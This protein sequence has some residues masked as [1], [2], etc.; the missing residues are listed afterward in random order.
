[1]SPRCRSPWV[2][3]AREF[4][5]CSPSLVATRSLAPHLVVADEL[6]V[7]ELFEVSAAKR[8]GPPPHSHPC[9]ETF[10]V[11]EGELV[12]ELGRY[13]HCAGPGAVVPVP[14]NVQH[15]YRGLSQRVRLVTLNSPA[16][17][18]AFFAQRHERLLTMPDDLP[19]LVEVAR[20]HGLRSPVF[21]E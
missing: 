6:A 1:V 12:F 19:A 11:L 8:S 18:H 3:A 15:P 5:S 21:A 2:E 4:I 16:E 10:Y 13:E 20:A 17:A 14:A 9:S 7:D